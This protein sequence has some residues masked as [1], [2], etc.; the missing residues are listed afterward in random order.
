MSQ[1][2]SSKRLPLKNCTGVGLAYV[3]RLRL[4]WDLKAGS[5]SSSGVFIEVEA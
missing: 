2:I 3:Y 1:T 5:E 4:S